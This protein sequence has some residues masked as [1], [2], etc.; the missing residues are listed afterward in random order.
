[1]PTD[2]AGAADPRGPRGDRAAGEVLAC[3]GLARAYPGVQALRDGALGL[4]AGE[5]HGLV[6]ENGAGKSTLVRILT[7]ATRP[8]AGELRLDGSPVRLDS[9]LEAR[10]AGIVPIY[11]EFS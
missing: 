8:D 10:R 4:R 9:P 6:G 7:G 5:V 11:Q 2:L 1:M 3:R